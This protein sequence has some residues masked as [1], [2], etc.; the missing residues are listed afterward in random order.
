MTDV[1][2]LDAEGAKA[3]DLAHDAAALVGGAAAVGGH[4]SA[5]A[6]SERVVTHEFE[7]LLPGYKG[8]RWAVTVSRVPRARHAT[9]DE[10]V[11]MPGP[12]ALVPAPW[13]P[14]SQRLQPGDLRPGDVLPTAPDDPRLVG[15]WSDMDAITL[16]ET[17]SDLGDDLGFDLGLTRAR[18]LS[19]AGRDE[20]AQHWYDGDSG[21]HAAVARAAADKCVSC[22]FLL[23]M[24]GSLGRM[25][26]VC[27][28]TFA[29]DDARVVS[30]DHGCGAHSE[31]VVEL[32][33]PVPVEEPFVD[34]E[35]ETFD[36]FEPLDEADQALGTL[37][38]DEK[39]ST[40]DVDAS[41]ERATDVD[42]E[43]TATAAAEAVDADADLADVELI[44][45]SDEHLAH[46]MAD[47]MAHG[48]DEPENT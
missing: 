45:A 26:G 18:V 5:H 15:G 33:S 2:E 11:L 9:V 36:R 34:E 14:W 8:W 12:D 44:A 32:T 23:P 13:V 43:S 10:V 1:I 31:V 7:S 17:V 35:F 46:E 39:E 29:A 3:A 28:N 19:F 41:V 20:V 16:E 30:F 22:G 21:P 4:V 38:T 25:F 47:E 42:D 6:E 40:L 48:S 37:T 24:A 27:G